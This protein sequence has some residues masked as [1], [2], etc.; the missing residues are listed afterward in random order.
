M[1]SLPADEYKGHMLAFA[2]ALAQLGKAL[3]TRGRLRE[4][5]DQVRGDLELFEREFAELTDRVRETRQ[6]ANQVR[7]ELLY[8][9]WKDSSAWD[10]SD[11]ER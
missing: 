1:T 9:L 3:E 4:V 10:D 8:S 7:H 5:I 2:E 11:E 6:K